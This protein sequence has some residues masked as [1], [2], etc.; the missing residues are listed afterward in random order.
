[1]EGEASSALH[2]HVSPPFELVGPKS[3]GTPIRLHAP[4]V[5]VET[6]PEPPD[7]NHGEAQV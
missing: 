2:G 1:M 3:G 6:N 5:R 4:M 7:F